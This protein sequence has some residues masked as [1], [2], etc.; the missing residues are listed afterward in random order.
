[1]NTHLTEKP[2]VKESVHSASSGVLQNR[3]TAN[4]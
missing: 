4:K 1:M 3:R 2:S